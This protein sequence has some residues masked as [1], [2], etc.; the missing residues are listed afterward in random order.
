[1]AH[2]NTLYEEHGAVMR[3][4]RRWLITG[5]NL[6]RLLAQN[7]T[8]EFHM[9]LEL[10]PIEERDNMYIGYV[11]QLER[12]LMEGS[13]RRLLQAS[14][15]VRS[16][17]YI[18]FLN[19][20]MDTVR[21]EIADCS[22][23]TYEKLSVSGATELLMFESNEETLAWAKNQDGWCHEADWFVFD[24]QSE[25]EARQLPFVDIIHN[26]MGYAHEMERIV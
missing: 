15:D 19:M 22:R 23:V 1:M 13:Y 5:L 14:K 3:S 16:N 20:L 25:V 2:L 10:I 26:Q 11:I 21:T 24:Q 6:L 7:K 18:V 4:E 9:M 8:M 17:E 12:Y